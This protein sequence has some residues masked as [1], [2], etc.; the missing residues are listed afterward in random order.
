MFVVLTT[1]SDIKLFIALTI[2]D[3]LA[4][5]LRACNTLRE[6]QVLTLTVYH[7]NLVKSNIL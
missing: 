1:A 7:L 6:S 3:P 2:S 4:F 5:E